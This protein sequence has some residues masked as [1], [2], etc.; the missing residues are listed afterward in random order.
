[1]IIIYII[2]Q[3]PALYV[4]VQLEGHDILSEAASRLLHLNKQ[5]IAKGGKREPT[6]A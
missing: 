4:K 1:M 2:I 3:F 5:Q 6:E